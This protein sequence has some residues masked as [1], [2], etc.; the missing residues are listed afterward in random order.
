MRKKPERR[1]RYKTLAPE[2][3]E[4]W[5]R[6][7]RTAEPLKRRPDRIAGPGEPE[8]A[9]DPAPAA[10]HPER[11]TAPE[12][13]RG[14]TREARRQRSDAPPP[15]AAFNRREAKELGAGRVAVEARIDLH[16]LR[17][18]EAYAALK[19]FLARAQA[20]GRRHVLVITGKGTP[21]GVAVGEENGGE[22]GVLRRAVP[23]WLERPELRQAVVS[24]TPAGPRH[25]GDGALYVRLRKPGKR[26]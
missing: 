17:Q 26:G 10:A 15:L 1:D 19:A 13:P 25:G 11:K 4:L 14:E 22:P 21:R 8:P 9:S 2:E 24:Y 18:R 23:L 20:Q 3:A 16:G 7:A 6:V 5:E 12:R